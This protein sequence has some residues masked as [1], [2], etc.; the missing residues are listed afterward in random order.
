[1]A[2]KTYTTFSDSSNGNSE[3]GFAGAYISN[4]GSNTHYA[5]DTVN[6]YDKRRWIG[7]DYS[8]Y[9][10]CYCYCAFAQLPVGNN[11]KISLTFTA[12]NGYWYG[13]GNSEKTMLVGYSLSAPA[14]GAERNSGKVN[15]PSGLTVSRFYLPAKSG[16]Y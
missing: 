12:N 9:G 11:L 6:W 7:S 3:F 16:T 1:M 14:S 5:Y 15:S 2:T 13:S 4:T 10:Y 8:G